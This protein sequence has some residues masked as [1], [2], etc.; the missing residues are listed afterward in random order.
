MDENYG[1]ALNYLRNIGIGDE[2]QE[3]IREKYL[4]G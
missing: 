2:I 1:G 3:T 4:E